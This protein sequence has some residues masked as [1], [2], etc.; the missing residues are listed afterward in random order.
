MINEEMYRLGD[1]RS[2]IRELFEYG[3]IQKAKLGEDKVFDFTLGNPSVPCPKEVND[4]ASYLLQN[5]DSVHAYTQAQG[6]LQTRQAIVKYNSDRYNFNLDA[7][8]I[9]MTCGAAAALKIVFSA[10]IS[11]P[12]E[13]ILAIS[14]FFPE[15]S[16]FAKT[17]GAVFK[18]VKCDEENFLVDFVELEKSI[19]KNTRALIINSPNNPSGTV[20]D[21]QTI[22]KI[23]QILDKKQKEYG[24]TIYLVSDE[25]Y[26][27]IVFEGND[28]PYIPCFYDNVIVCYSYS[29]ALSLPGERI[30]YIAVSPK[31]TDS[32]KLYKAINGAGRALGY[33]CAPSLFQKVIA[34]HIDTI[35]DFS[36]YKDNRDILIENLT[37][38]GFTCV[39]PKGA[40]YLFVK[41][42]ISDAVKF[43]ES[44]KKYNLLV[45]PSNSF[46]VTGYVRIATCVSKETAINSKDAFTKL[47][48][49]YNLIW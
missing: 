11:E 15:Y 38:L 19:T 48:K 20:Y 45:V 5:D 39:N 6:D 49:E 17:S 18:F 28:C 41:S 33:V 14:P 2:I 44:A 37:K 12:S 30:G 8:L 21:S 1:T 24:T 7:N 32:E 23:S 31:A 26:K 36:V 34:K 4:Y 43:S 3:R 25:P 47:A 35:S 46:G 29:K 27:E 13:E 42:P 40:F 10:I 16:V 9:Y 22:S